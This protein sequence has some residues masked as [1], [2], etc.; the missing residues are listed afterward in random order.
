MGLPTTEDLRHDLGIIS[1][2]EPATHDV[3]KSRRKGVTIHKQTEIHLCGHKVV[4]LN[5]SG[6]YR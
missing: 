3:E 6:M 4:L 2:P 5:L 1:L